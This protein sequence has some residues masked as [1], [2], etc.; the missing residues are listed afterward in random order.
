MADC[1]KLLPDIVANQIKAG[2]VVESPSSVV[3]EMV[4]NAIDAGATTVRVNYVN[5]GRDLIQII[6]NGRGMSPTDARMAFECH[7]TSKIATLD[8]IYALHTFGFRGEA[9]SS[10][11]AVSQVELLTRQEDVEVGT[12]TLINGGEFISQT[13]EACPVGAQFLVRN[14]FYNTPA[15]RK[16]IDKKEER[17]GQE[18]KR[19]FRRVALCHPE[20]ELEL[21]HDGAP[22]YSLP[23][24]NLA[25]RIVDV[26]G[27]TMKRHLLEVDVETS[28]V[29][30]FGYVGRPSVARRGGE[31]YMFVNGRFFASTMLKRAVLKAYEHLIPDGAEPSFFI[32][33][34][35]NPERVDVNVHAK[36]TEVKFADETAIWQILNAAVR[37]TLAKSGAVP[38]MDFDD[39]SDIE[40]PIARQGVVY[41]AEPRATINDNYNP[42]TVSL[43]SDGGR[44]AM[45]P[46]S[47]F[48]PSL[49]VEEFEMPSMDFGVATEDDSSFD[50]IASD[51]AEEQYLDLVAESEMHPSNIT[52]L[53]RNYAMLQLGSRLLLADLMRVRERLFYD[54]YLVQLGGG[55]AVSQQLLYPERL[56]V[57]AEEYDLLD[58]YAV[59]FASLGFDIELVGD[60][61]VEVRGVPAEAVSERVDMAL[62]DMLQILRTPQSAVDARRE[63]LAATLA[64]SEAMRRTT[65]SQGE[66]ERLLV[67]LC[68]S[69]NIS[70]TPSGKQ[71]VAE[72]SFDEIET[73]LG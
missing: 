24:A 69:G 68:A 56:T 8:D 43:P 34:T 23:I 17:L 36:K 19:E 46:N 73:K 32:Y 41:S 29:K 44:S 50:F 16:F 49:S 28:I 31:H 7:A 15:R 67:Q 11:A 45:A 6:D 12:R 9:L 20:V 3:K 2:E 71:I 21:L 26:M 35:V 58:E 1:I 14:I 47:D 38:L 53:G 40:I 22:L 25:E 64:R 18:I 65:F 54:S 42:F 57:T 4:E 51:E 30:I 72:L 62:Y 13:P 66:A 33:M 48:D 5:G 52:F 37:E 10:I 63:A 27:D 59:D 55:H 39:S 60:G 61:V 70:Y